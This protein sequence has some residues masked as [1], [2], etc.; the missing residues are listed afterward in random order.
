VPGDRGHLRVGRATAQTLAGLG[1]SVV[2]LGRRA[3]ELDA[4]AGEIGAS[5]G[6]HD[7]TGLVADLVS[8][9]SIR[10]AADRFL[11]TYD[12]WSTTPGSR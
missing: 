12:R 6:N 2:L 7:V 3:S 1:A 9:A 10:Q 8:L 5:T 4:V 11:T